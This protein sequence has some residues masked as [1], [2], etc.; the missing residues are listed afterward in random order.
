[1]TARSISTSSSSK[2]IHPGGWLVALAGGAALLGACG[3]ASSS[4]RPVAA[5]TSTLAALRTT[6]VYGFDINPSSDELIPAPGTT[7]GVISEGDQSIVNDQLTSTHLAGHGASAG[8][9]IIGYDSGTCT[10]TRVAPDGQP[11]GSAF[12]ATL[13]DCVVTAFLPNGSVTAQG[14]ITLRSG[15]PQPAQLAVTGGTGSF[16]GANGTVRVTFGSHYQGQEYK[17]LTISVQ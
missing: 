3:A 17:T 14:V 11:S 8:Y 6:V 16:D 13:E 1:M 10:F 12:D 5:P 4:S 15:T 7:A 9:P 2:W